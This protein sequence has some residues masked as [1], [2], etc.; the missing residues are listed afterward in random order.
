VSESVLTDAGGG[1]L[2]ASEVAH[3]AKDLNKECDMS[4]NT[5]LPPLAVL[6]REAAVKLKRCAALGSVHPSLTLLGFYPQA[7][8]IVRH[9]VRA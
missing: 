3:V 1:A 8:L 6:E 5:G 4:A 9:Q 2:E 7:T